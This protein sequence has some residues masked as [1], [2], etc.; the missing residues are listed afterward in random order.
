LN[1]LKLKNNTTMENITIFNNAMFGEIRVAGTSEQPLFCAADVCKALG[2]AN[3]RDA[4]VKHVDTPD[5]AKCDIGVITGKKADGSNAYQTVSLS[6]VNESGLYSLIFGSKLETAKQFKRWVTSEVLPSIRKHGG[7]LTDKTIDEIANDPDLLMKLA[8]ALK[9][10]KQK[11]LAAEQEAIE[12]QLQI[13]EDRPKVVLANAIT[14]SKT[15]ILIGE[16][17]KIMRQN[18]VPTGEKRMFEYMRK[19]GYLC[20]CGERYNKPTQKAMEMGLFELK[21]TSIIAGD[22]HKVVSTT[23]ITGKGQEYFANKFLTESTFL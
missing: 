6:F 22:V 17:A 4:I 11:R 20:A 19:N 7:Y 15:S 14:T 16:F 8:T 21:E 3:G 23:K 12:K 1:D 2:Y 9:E 10:E 5:V 13:E 18:G